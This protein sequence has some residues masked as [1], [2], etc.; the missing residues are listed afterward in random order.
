MESDSIIRMGEMRAREGKQA[1]L[2][3]FI[4]R[5]IVPA[6]QTADGCRGCHVWQ[7]DGEP[8]RFLI[9]EEWESFAAHQASVK[10]INPND[11]KAIMELLDDSPA[12][13]YYRI[14]DP[15]V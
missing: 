4:A 8:G 6:L 9:V 14:V 11:I 13:H 7:A 10:Q 1:Q 15:G 12:G 5:V 2:H 3:A